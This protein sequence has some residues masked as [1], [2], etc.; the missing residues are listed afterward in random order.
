MNILALLYFIGEDGQ[1]ALD[2]V[3]FDIIW[4]LIQQCS[5][6][7]RNIYGTEETTG[8]SSIK[9]LNDIDEKK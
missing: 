2:F 4:Y 9:K 7:L 6:L 1:N 3:G 8:L 5:A